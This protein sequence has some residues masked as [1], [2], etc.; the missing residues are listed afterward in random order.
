[1]TLVEYGKK[2]LE[3]INYENKDKL[4]KILEVIDNQGHSN[5]SI[6]I[7]RYALKYNFENNSEFCVIELKEYCKDLTK[8]DL[9]YLQMLIDFKPLSKLTL[10]EDEWFE[11]SFSGTKQNK[12]KFSLF[13]TKNGY[14]Y[15]NAF[16]FIN[17][18]NLCY[19]GRIDITIIDTNKTIKLG[20]CC[21]I[22]VNKTPTIYINVLEDKNGNV[23]T[24]SDQIEK[25]EEYYYI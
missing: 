18:K 25:I 14:E 11:E 21:P 16:S 22:D 12:R 3:I 13:K 24:T 6:S 2:E 9:E 23:Y 17:Q 20:S 4:L 10:K 15:S 7:I 8:K 1:M 5:S 19:S